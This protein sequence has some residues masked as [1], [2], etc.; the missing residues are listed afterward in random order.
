LPGRVGKKALE[1]ERRH[2]SKERKEIL[3]LEIREEARSAEGDPAKRL[4]G[5]RR[6]EEKRE[7]GRLLP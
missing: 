7:E 1:R 6:P 2:P 5:G 4:I 3:R